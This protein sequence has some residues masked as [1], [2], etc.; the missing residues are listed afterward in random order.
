M[1]YKSKYKGAQIDE[2]VGKV[3]NNEIEGGGDSLFEKGG[4]ENSAVLKEG[5]NIAGL[6]GWYYKAIQFNTNT[7]NMYLYLTQTQQLQ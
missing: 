3:L 2:A 6:K 4:S 7:G 1:G 5:N